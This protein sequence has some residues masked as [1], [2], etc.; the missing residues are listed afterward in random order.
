MILKI[1]HVYLY[2]KYNISVMKSIY[3]IITAFKIALFKV[4]ATY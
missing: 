4:S 2:D 1:S 3:Y